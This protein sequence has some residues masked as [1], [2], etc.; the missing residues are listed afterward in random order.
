MQ[1]NSFSKICHALNMAVSLLKSFKVPDNAP[2]ADAY[3]FAAFISDLESALKTHR[4]NC[5]VGTAEEQF[6]RHDRYC[7]SQPTCRKCSEMNGADL[8]VSC[9][10]KWA[11]MPYKE[12]GDK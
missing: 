10:A 4:R 5:D 12:G 1:V 7:A 2:D 3:K 9:F 11:Q 6:V 8:C